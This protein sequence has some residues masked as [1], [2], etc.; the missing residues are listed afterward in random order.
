MNRTKTLFSIIEQIQPLL[1]RSIPIGNQTNGQPRNGEHVT[2]YATILTTNV[3]ASPNNQQPQQIPNNRS[4]TYA[5][6]QFPSTS[7][8]EQQENL[9][10][11]LQTINDSETESDVTTTSP[12]RTHRA[13]G[14]DINPSVGDSS[15]K[16]SDVNVVRQLESSVSSLSG[17]HENSTS[18]PTRNKIKVDSNER[19]RPL[20][21]ETDF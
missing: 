8:G 2:P 3:P 5:Q 17:M 9:N 11:R 14:S 6:I 18:P 16:E 20:S 10:F 21:P 4:L 1:L 15:D 13:F 19:Q 7:A 12:N